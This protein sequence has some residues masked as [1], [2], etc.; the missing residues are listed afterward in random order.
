MIGILSWIF[1]DTTNIANNAEEN[2]QKYFAIAPHFTI[3]PKT[4]E[5]FYR[6]LKSIYAIDDEPLHI[7]LI[8]PDHFETNKETIAMLCKETKKFCYK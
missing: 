7:V 1:G 6:T 4:V 5:K 2:Q 8:S 3:Q